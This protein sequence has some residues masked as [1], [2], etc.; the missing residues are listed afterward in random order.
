[1][2]AQFLPDYIIRDSPSTKGELGGYLYSLFITRV[3]SPYSSPIITNP[4]PSDT[5]PLSPGLGQH[6]LNRV[7]CSGDQHV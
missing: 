2:E 7:P 4:P 3:S 1:M 5:Q 6:T